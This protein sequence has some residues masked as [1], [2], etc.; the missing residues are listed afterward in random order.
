MG[1]PLSSKDGDGTVRSDSLFLTNSCWALAF[2]PWDLE[3][4]RG[5]NNGTFIGCRLPEQPLL[6]PCWHRPRSK[7]LRRDGE[8]GQ[9]LLLCPGL[10]PVSLRSENQAV[11]SSRLSPDSL[12]WVL[13]TVSSQSFR[14][15]SF[16]ACHF[17]LWVG[18]NEKG[19]IGCQETCLVGPGF[20]L[21]LVGRL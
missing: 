3:R 17:S 10:S 20:S 7:G 19:H 4:F 9:S 6:W 21:P 5:G 18:Y 8:W 11:S 1:E 15:G 13:E 14:L 16:C 2:P 12:R